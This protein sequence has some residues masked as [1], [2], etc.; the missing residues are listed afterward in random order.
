MTN[1]LIDCLAHG[2]FLIAWIDRLGR[3]CFDASMPRF[4]APC[5]PWIVASMLASI[6]ASMLVSKLASIF[7][8][9][10]AS[11]LASM[12]RCLLRYSL[13]YSF[14]CL[15]S[16]IPRFFDAPVPCCD[17]SLPRFDTRLD[18]HF[19]TRFEI[20]F[21]ICS[22]LFDA[23]TPR[24]LVDNKYKERHIQSVLS[25]PSFVTSTR[26][27]VVASLDVKFKILLVWGWLLCEA[28]L[29]SIARW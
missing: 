5:L 19:D 14:G 10:L 20:C 26:R 25:V 28:K 15:D 13:G 3:D 11:M 18:N 27:S 23:S 21:E 16:S 6:L 1:W 4:D 12:L 22:R 17:A 24:L 7:A 8:L 2:L 29:D 9:L